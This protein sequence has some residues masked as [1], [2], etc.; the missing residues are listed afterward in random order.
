[1]LD[2]GDGGGFEGINPSMLSQL[3]KALSGGVSGAQPVA[4]SYVGQFSR[5]GLDTG[6]VNKLLAD[7]AWAASQQPMLQRRYSLASHQPPGSWTD[8]W[9]TEGAGTLLY[10][11]TGAAKS[12]GTA[13]AQQM[14]QYL[15]DN[16]WS[17]IQ[18]ELDN[19]SANQ[20]DADYMAAFFSQIGPTG[21]Y[22]LSTYAQ[23]GGVSKSDEQ[24]VQSVVG[25][26]LATASY[27][28][29]LTWKFLQGI[30]SDREPPGYTP[31]TLP[32]GWDSGALAPFLTQGE[33]SSQWLNVIAPTVL[34]QRDVETGA[35][36]PGGYDAIFQ[37]MAGNPGF[38]A[39]FYSQNSGQLNEYMTDPELQNYLA[40][41]QGFG[42][43]LEAATIAP[44]G[45]SDTKP[46]TDNATAFV[47]LFG[48]GKTDTTAAVRQAMAAVAVQ[49]FG[50]IQG[51]VT[52]A[53]QG[54]GST[55]GLTSTE[56]GSFVQN[57]MR[58]KDA[59]AFLMT[60]YANWSSAQPMNNVP[61]D[62]AGDNP[63]T[64]QR[65]GYWPTSS[66]GLL[67]Y[68]FASNYQ[69]AG[70]TAGDGGG[71]K[72][73]LISALS[74]GGATL[75]TSV[76]FGPEAGAFVITA[77]MLKDA[78]KDVFSSAAE[79][80]LKTIGGKLTEGGPDAGPDALDANLTNIQA[81]WSDAVGRT[82]RDSQST[83][84]HSNF[85][86]VQYN[87]VTYN[88]DPLTYEKQYGG[89][90]MNADGTVKSSMNAQELTAYNA[91]LQD[92]AVSSQVAPYFTSRNGG[93]VMAFYDNQM[94][95]PGG[96][97]AGGN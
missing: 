5:L 89:Y 10:S 77:D 96:G 20:G 86:A 2:A 8:G 3:I 17:G 83:P 14:Q 56:W 78:G 68:F 61:Q 12:A 85:P 95:G 66:L 52:A 22:A 87:G 39:Q 6:P 48:G 35:P 53:A 37:A 60:F 58:D 72:D 29:P 62:G 46:Y 54:A 55:M 81:Q 97:G 91:W 63:L 27:E 94:S 71:I 40:S 21:L 73:T 43:F 23:G 38:A 32:G 9:T 67:D 65:A 34:Y 57:A 50:D 49:Y 28:M 19:L 75:L 47:Q 74:A 1:M 64:P 36:L 88:G 45:T 33:Y 79:D 15:A 84:G 42:K 13:D 93:A 82:W 70:A 90:F 11:S 31:E 26:S 59:A 76:V 51:T 41:G 44:P 80:T 69:A 18:K 4:G 24:E 7:Y 16:D 25:N 30:Q 92:P